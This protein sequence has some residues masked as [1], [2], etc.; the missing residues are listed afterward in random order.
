MDDDADVA[1]DRETLVLVQ[2]VR[3]M[4]YRGLQLRESIQ[5]LRLESYMRRVRH[6]V[7]TAH[8]NAREE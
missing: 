7:L 5:R 8:C 4:L 3:E 6:A 1:A 2:S